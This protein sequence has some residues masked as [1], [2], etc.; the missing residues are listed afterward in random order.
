[1]NSADLV[2]KLV[3]HG[4]EQYNRDEAEIIGALAATT[5]P[6]LPCVRPEA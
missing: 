1:V 5:S 4:S 6:A 2:E 3:C